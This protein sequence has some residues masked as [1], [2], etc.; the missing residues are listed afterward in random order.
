MIIRPRT[1]GFICTTA[2]PVGCAENVKDAIRTMDQIK[3]RGPKNV[4]VIGS[5]TGY[6]L[7]SRIAAAFGYGSATIGVAYE[8]PAGPSHTATAG[9][10][11]TAAFDSLAA[12]Q[13]LIS[14]SLYGDAFSDEMKTEVIDTI[15]SL[16]PEGKIDLVIYSVAAPKRTDPR[17]GI[18]WSSVIKPIAA[19]FGS[20]TVNVNSGVISEAR[21]LP[22]TEEEIN[23]T[24]KVMGGEDWHWWME[25]LAGAGVLDHNVLTLAYSYIGPEIT[26]PIYRDGTIG[27]AKQDLYQTAPRITG[28]LTGLQGHAFV[29]VNKAVVTQAS[30]AIPVVPLYISLLNKVM[31]NKGLHEDCSR[32]MKRMFERLYHRD[33]I[34][35]WAQVPVDGEGLIRMDDLEMREDVQNEVLA[36]WEQVSTENSFTV[37]D[38]EGYNLAFLQ[39]FGFAVPGVDYEQD[40]PL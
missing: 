2:H 7:A 13:G 38:I 10:Y 35:D 19:P 34:S 30:S 8:R 24:V 26:H 11:N 21:V 3:G 20:K 22:A 37:A 17:T 1:K 16:M 33:C 4:L 15:R 40:V 12:E 6:G 9:W 27:L 36:L 5:S 25:A 18:T 39:L 23:S 29:A 31:K 28:L 32:Q 14:K